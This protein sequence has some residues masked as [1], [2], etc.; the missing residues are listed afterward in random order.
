VDDSAHVRDAFR[1]SVFNSG[2]LLR[3]PANGPD[4]PPEQKAAGHHMT[5][6][7]VTPCKFRATMLSVNRCV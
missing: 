7:D 6:T 5:S 2:R 3:T 4:P 1:S